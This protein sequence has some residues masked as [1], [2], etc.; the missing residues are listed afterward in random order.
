MPA[1]EDRS[2]RVPYALLTALALCLMLAAPAAAHKPT[3]RTPGYPGLSAVP[4]FSSGSSTKPGKPVKLGGGYRPHLLVDG[5]GTGHIVF[6]TSGHAFGP[7]GEEQ[8]TAGADHYCRLPRGATRCASTTTFVVPEIYDSG[9]G[10]TSPYFDN[11]PGFNTDI[12]E[13]ARPLASGSSLLLLMHRSRNVIQVPGGYSDDANF[14]YSSDDGGNTFTG[15][16]IVGTLDYESGAVVYGSGIQSIGVLGTTPTTLSNDPSHD[17]FQGTPAGAFA[18]ASEIGQLDPT[19]GS[20]DGRSLALDG[21]RPVAAFN[22]LSRVTVREY[23]GSGDINSP[24]SWTESSLKGTAATL[25]GGPHGAWLAYQPIGITRREVVVKLA[26]GRPV[27]RPVAVFPQLLASQDNELTADATGGLTAAW[28][29]RDPQHTDSYDRLTISQSTDGRHWSRPE[30]IARGPHHQTLSGLQIATAPD[31]GGFAMYVH[32]NVNDGNPLG[33]FSLGGQVVA[34]PFGPGGPTGQKGLGGLGGSGGTSGCLDV[35]FGDVHAHVDAGC[36]LR[37]PADPTGSAAIAYGGV[38][39]NGLELRPDAPG[40]AIVIDPRTHTI[41]GV[42]GTVSILLQAAGVPD[43]K[44][45]D[46]SL[47]AFLGAQDH[48][49]DLLFG[50]PMTGFHANVLGF[51]ALGLVDVL[52]GKESVQIPMALKLPQYMHATAQATLV[53]DSAH[54]LERSSLRVS[55]P[56]LELGGLEVSHMALDYSGPAEQWT[57]TAELNVPPGSGTAGMDVRGAVVTFNHG[58]FDTGG[59]QSD[60]FPGTA[61]YRNAFLNSFD[62]AFDLHPTARISGNAELGAIPQGSNGYALQATGPYAIAFGSPSV[63]SVDGDG[64]IEGVPLSSAHA[65]FTTDGQFTETGSI[66]LDTSGLTLAG[67]VDATATLS[68]GSIAGTV[69]GT[70]AVEG[71]TLASKTIP[72]NSDGFGVCED[73]GVGPFKVSAGFVYTWS[74]GA[75]VHLLDCDTAASASA[76]ASAARA[77]ATALGFSVAAGSDV[78][79]LT[80]H[81]APG[82]PRI[83]L[84][85]P[86]G[87]TVI[88]STTDARA[89]AIELDFPKGG[90]TAVAIRHPAAGVWHLAPAAGS[91]PISSVIAARGYPPPALRARVAGAGHRRAVVYRVALHPGLIVRFAEVRRGRVLAVI[92]RARSGRGR[93]AFAPAAG[94][95]GSRQIVALLS[96]AGT[97]PGSAVL[98]RYRAPV[99]LRPGKAGVRLSHRGRE[100]VIRIR[101]AAGATRYAVSA[102]TADGRRVRTVIG[103]RRLQLRVPAAGWSDRIVVTVTPLGSSGR[104]GPSTRARLHVRFSAPH[105]TGRRAKHPSHG[106]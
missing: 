57:G 100:F 10:D 98:T 23:R 58:D 5:A 14:L 56:D 12:G 30:I 39:V 43:I 28:V 26:H 73:S 66:G 72:F 96:G 46:G 36:F 68:D 34:V 87:Q 95:A 90:L 32:G 8:T 101:R 45:W 49:G 97:V 79:E 52:L 63:M 51:E 48:A 27:G 9:P 69:S 40:T 1:E 71:Q 93:I 29:A 33:A 91:A 89:P 105:L 106:R 88:P 11:Q 6:S 25:A 81:G 18:P 41:D 75:E 38:H 99:S 31:G 44:L 102:A 24:S 84:T 64:A 15:P 70:F 67:L 13:G 86:S 60:P 74:G 76:S 7:P 16:G 47:H 83:T 94:P 104:A 92:G 4:K 17:Y 103:T 19:Y 80:L 22:T 53:A 2:V 77:R 59:F 62:A 65:T 50:L 21:T 78:E 82:S 20:G 42:H 35:R 55:V 54:N 85:S 37:D 3:Y 61:V